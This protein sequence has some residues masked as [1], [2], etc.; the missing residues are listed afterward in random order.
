MTVEDFIRTTLVEITRG[1][2]GA[3]VD[4]QEDGS[5]AR[6]NPHMEGRGYK[7]CDVECDIA[8]TAS[9]TGG[10]S[11]GVTVLGVFGGGVKGESRHEHV[12]VSRIKFTIPILLPTT[13]RAS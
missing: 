3:Q 13:P 5:D 7:V 8:V 2:R 11:A 4:V 10:A 12:H 6:V 9:S 1:V